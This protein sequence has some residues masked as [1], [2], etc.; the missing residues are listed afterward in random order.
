MKNI[1]KDL[2]NF[3]LFKRYEKKCD[4][5]YFCES[6]FIYNYIEPYIK[7]KNKKKNVV[8]ISFENINDK[9]IEQNKFFVFKSNF[10]RELIFLSLNL[11]YLYSSTPDLNYTIFKKSKLN[12]CK[13]I[14]LQHT[15]VSLTMIYNEKAFVAFDAVQVI[16]SFQFKEMLEIKNKFGLN[17]KI[18]K[19]EY[20]FT[21]KKNKFVEDKIVDVL[22]APTW[23][24]N[25]YKLDCHKSLKKFLD[26]KN[27]SYKIRP[28][29]MSYNKGEIKKYDLK[30]LGMNI[31]DDEFVNFSKYKFF[32][33]DWSGLFIEY[34]I[35]FKRKSYLINTPKKIIN[36]NYKNFN[37]TPIEISLRNIFCKTYEI[38]DIGEIIKDINSIKENNKSSDITS[39][40]LD[41]K[42][43]I[44]KNF[45]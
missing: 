14:Y 39:I 3:I 12:K 25:F 37:S 23:N 19:S 13:Y 21:K 31:Y 44:D 38:N 22:I 42:K 9:D 17:T 41:I 1:F 10:F 35:I 33:S 29:P 36:K 45:Y 24:S 32:I 20:L 11:K 34:A 27:I 30:N 7:K 28:H 16:S 40:D 18:F 4:V 43:I 5:G 15:P 6:K 2:K 26:Q 8:I